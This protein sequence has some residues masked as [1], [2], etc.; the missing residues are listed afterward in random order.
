MPWDCNE[1]GEAAEFVDE[2]DEAKRLGAE[3]LAIF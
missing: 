2:I 3:K 1:K